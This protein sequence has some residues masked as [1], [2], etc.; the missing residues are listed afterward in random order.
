MSASRDTAIA[1]A[2]LDALGLLEPAVRVPLHQDTGLH[3]WSPALDFTA[4]VLG[5]DGPIENPRDAY[6]R[7]PLRTAAG[8]LTIAEVEI[9]DRLRAAGWRAGWLDSF[10]GAPACW[11]A[12]LWTEADLPD[13][14]LTLFAAVG[15]QV[16]NRW[17]GRPDVVAWRDG[18]P[19]DVV[20]LHYKGARDP[21][22]PSQQDWVRAAFAAGLPMERYALARWWG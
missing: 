3:V 5:V 10:G 18:A 12:R 4:W 7:T 2:W 22:R 19:D 16:G 11:A 17:R 15:E 20:Y 6:R 9:V 21:V 8:A 14:A 13:G 1:P